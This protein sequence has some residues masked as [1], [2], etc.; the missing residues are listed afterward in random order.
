MIRICNALESCL[1]LRSPRVSL[2]IIAHLRTCVSQSDSSIQQCN[3]VKSSEWFSF[4]FFNILTFTWTFRTPTATKLGIM[5]HTLLYIHWQFFQGYSPRQIF[6]RRGKFSVLPLWNTS[7]FSCLNCDLY[8]FVQMQ[9][10]VK[11]SSR[12][13]CLWDAALCM[14]TEHGVS[15]Q[16]SFSTSCVWML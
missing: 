4:I 9:E 6:C 1:E 14:C 7:L 11:K 12:C 8:L 3:S 15:T 16:F 5:I 2:K 10:E 13:C